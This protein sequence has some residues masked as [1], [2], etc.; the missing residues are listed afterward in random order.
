MLTECCEPGAGLR[1][2]RWTLPLDDL[3]RAADIVHDDEQKI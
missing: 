1:L 2:N 3:K